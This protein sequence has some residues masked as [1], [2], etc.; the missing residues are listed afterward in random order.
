[1][2]IG[3]AVCPADGS[4][5]V[6][7]LEAADRALH[8]AEATGRDRVVAAVPGGPDGVPVPAASGA[9]VPV[10]VPGC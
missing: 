3:A 4:D 2:G 5:P 1:V 7:L 6:R 9:V 10:P 8:T